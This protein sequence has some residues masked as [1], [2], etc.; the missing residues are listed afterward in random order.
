MVKEEKVINQILIYFV[1]VYITLILISNFNL[2]IE[3]IDKNII[4]IIIFLILI[5]KS[6]KKDLI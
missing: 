2:K 3:I 4:I 1:I 6:I 5:Y